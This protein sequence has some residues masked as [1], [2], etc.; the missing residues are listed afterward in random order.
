[1]VSVYECSPRVLAYAPCLLAQDL[2]E[3][4]AFI[5]TKFSCQKRDCYGGSFIEDIADNCRAAPRRALA[6][7][8]LQTLQKSLEETTAK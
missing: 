7:K 4:P 5:G 8:R 6:S 1:V 3:Q 2:A